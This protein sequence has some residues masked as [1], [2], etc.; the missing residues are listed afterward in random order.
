MDGAQPCT[1]VEQT[2]AQFMLVLLLFFYDLIVL[3]I[4]SYWMISFCAKHRRNV[5]QA[6]SVAKS[7]VLSVRHPLP[8]IVAYTL[9]LICVF[10]EGIA[11][12]YIFTATTKLSRHDEWDGVNQWTWAHGAPIFYGKEIDFALHLMFWFTFWT[13]AQTKVFKLWML[14]YKYEYLKYM[15][16]MEW[17]E[18]LGLRTMSGTSYFIRFR[19]ILGN[20]PF[21]FFFQL[22]VVMIVVFIQILCRID[23]VNGDDPTKNGLLAEMVLCLFVAV[24][25]IVGVLYLMRNIVGMEDHL[26]LKKEG[27]SVFLI[28]AVGLLFWILGLIL[29]MAMR[30]DLPFVYARSGQLVLFT[31]WVC[32]L[33]YYET[34]FVLH[35]SGASG[36][37]SSS[38]G[39]GGGASSPKS[40]SMG[41]RDHDGG[42][43]GGTDSRHQGYSLQEVLTVQVGFEAMMR[44]LVKEFSCENLLCFVELCQYINT[45]RSNY[46]KHNATDVSADSQN[47]D[48]LVAH[49][50][51]NSVSPDADNEDAYSFPIEDFPYFAKPIFEDEL[52]HYEY[53][54]QKYINNDASLQINISHALRQEAQTKSPGMVD[55]NSLRLF[56]KIRK[57][58]W[59]LMGDSF[60][61]F[62]STQEYKRLKLNQED[63]KRAL[64]GSSRGMRSN[65]A[66]RLADSDYP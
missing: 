63:F 60:Q 37:K 53:I 47:N 21:I 14:R 15:N 65:H 31:T 33:C 44:F 27:R 22:V 59:G 17:K 36:G 50:Q 24:L 4:C 5:P 19:S 42:G 32:V 40:G 11:N 43:G 2:R 38:G 55:A 48:K 23:E 62:R 49:P 26:L 56:D 6:Y 57:E 10:E 45:W 66:E 35:H 39:G 61:R 34:I 1:V 20:P 7:I 30:T 64:S 41:S 51:Q 58:L 28:S 16:N 52:G 29:V 9:A 46:Q 13:F 3:G 25:D 18:S 54:Q 8:I 12:I